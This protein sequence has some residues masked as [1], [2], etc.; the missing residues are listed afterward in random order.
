M[1]LN[2]SAFQA[3]DM[4]YAAGTSVPSSTTGGSISTPKVMFMLPFSTA[5]VIVPGSVPKVSSADSSF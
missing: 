2:I 4:S 1:R 5:T 3:F